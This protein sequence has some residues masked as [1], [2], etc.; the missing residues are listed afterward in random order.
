MLLFQKLVVEGLI[1]AQSLEVSEVT[2]LMSIQELTVSGLL[3]VAIVVLWRRMNAAEE[4]IEVI[5][6]EK[7]TEYQK[8]VELLIKTTQIIDENTKMWARMERLFDK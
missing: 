2:S 6:K 1:L 8:Y 5:R 4:K 3:L 7:D